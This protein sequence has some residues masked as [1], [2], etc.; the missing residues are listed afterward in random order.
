M[1]R[2]VLTALMLVACATA[3]CRAGAIPQ[4]EE[5][6]TAEDPATR[7]A[8]ELVH[9]A[10]KRC[11]QEGGTWTLPYRECSLRCEAGR[12]WSEGRDGGVCHIPPPDQRSMGIIRLQERCESDPNT[13]V[14]WDSEG[15]HYICRG[16]RTSAY[17]PDGGECSPLLRM[18]GSAPGIAGHT[19]PADGG[20]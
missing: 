7:K 13:A 8:S 17:L 18:L 14:E 15:C 1:F 19:G 6:V 12:F 10:G 3:G 5:G 20:Q 11:S 16:G 2:C 9:W 4:T